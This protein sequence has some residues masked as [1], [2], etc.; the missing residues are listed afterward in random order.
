MIGRSGTLGRISSLV[1]L[2]T[3]LWSGAVAFGSGENPTGE[4]DPTATLVPRDVA[5]R[6]AELADPRWE[7]RDAASRWL[8]CERR[9][10]IDALPADWVP[11]D[12]EAAW[13]W[14]TVLGK[15]RDLG[16]L[17]HSLDHA[18]FDGLAWKLCALHA[19]LAGEVVPEALAPVLQFPEERL[20]ERAVRLFATLGSVDL[21]RWLAPVAADPSP[22]VRRSLYALAVERD[23]RWAVALV[24]EALARG[25]R[26]AL[27]AE[28]VAAV[29]R[30]DHQPHLARLR[31]IWDELASGDRYEAAFAL[32]GR[33]AAADRPVLAWMLAS[34]D[35]RLLLLALSEMESRA[36][37]AD[38]LALL[39]LIE[40]EYGEVRVRTCRLL[41]RI[42]AREHAL[43]VL[44]YLESERP[45]AVRF[46]ADRLVTWD[47]EE[48]FG[49]LELAL[50]RSPDIGVEIVARDGHAHI[51]RAPARTAEAAI[52]PLGGVAPAE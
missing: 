31:A 27:F 46:A 24:D 37:A 10:W 1:L 36:E 29:R 17:P 32:C 26:G 5:A 43:E 45:E 20:R 50:A 23:P 11:R 28:V 19:E 8:V 9:R 48:Y 6:L 3:S 22:W 18:S 41:E 15:V 13:R 2:W 16:S 44:P 30:L 38:F 39:P 4:A 14:A 51:V 33:S 47:A 35:Y 42:G 25:E 21:P 34:G 40:S 12:P 7:V 49:D 52:V